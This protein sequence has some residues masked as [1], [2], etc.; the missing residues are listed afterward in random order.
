M[1]DRTT[2]YRIAF[3]RIKGINPSVAEKIL[4]HVDS[5]EAFFSLSA[6]ELSSR[7]P[8]LPAAMIAAG[9]RRTLAEAAEAELSFMQKSGVK[10][11][12][13]T[14]SDYPA[15]LAECEDAPLLLYT[16][17]ETSLNA[18]HIISIVGTRRATPYGIAF[19][20]NL[21]SDLAAKLGPDTVIVSGLAYG[22]DI[23]AHRAALHAGIPTVAVLAHGLNTLYPAAHRR[24]AAEILRAGGSMLTEYASQDT[25]HRGNFIARNR[26]VA[27]MAAVSYT[28]LRAHETS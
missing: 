23:T 24:T 12:Y 8:C 5:E 25:L 18:P 11:L 9:Y 7:M 26:I 22:I 27:G 4:Q 19:V 13:F 1:T 15:R 3:S 2:I 28:H 21:V 16:L 17:G 10:P 6:Q 20:E 14:D